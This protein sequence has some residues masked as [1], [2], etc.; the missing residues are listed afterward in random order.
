[1]FLSTDQHHWLLGD[2]EHAQSMTEH[3]SAVHSCRCPCHPLM[4]A[5]S[6][7]PGHDAMQLLQI[8]VRSVAG[9]AHAVVGQALQRVWRLQAIPSDKGW[10]RVVPIAVL[11]DVVPCRCKS[12]VVGAWTVLFFPF[13]WRGEEDRWP[14]RRGA[15]ISAAKSA[16]ASTAATSPAR[17]TQAVP[18]PPLLHPI[19]SMALQH[20]LAQEHLPHLPERQSPSCQPWQSPCRRGSSQT[21]RPVAGKAA[22]G[23]EPRPK[24]GHRS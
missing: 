16:A 22:G 3:V 9:V 8:P 4:H 5:P 6:S 11:V 21:L 1:M 15:G 17:C 23:R 7:N 24:A 20:D 19:T 10:V 18:A 13:F 12:V 2:A 14:Q